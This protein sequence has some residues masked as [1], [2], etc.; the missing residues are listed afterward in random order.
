MIDVL[1]VLQNAWRN[2]APESGKAEWKPRYWRRALWRSQTSKRL[3]EMIPEGITYEVCNASPLVG[4]TSKAVFQADRAHLDRVV[5]RFCPSLTVLLGT[6]AH[7]A[8]PWL[9]PS[10]RVLTG[11]HPAYR[12]LFKATTAE[13]REKI[14]QCLERAGR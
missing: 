8:Q 4:S 10:T 1:F 3:R 13:I 9:E 14:M 7:K 2:G 11:P 6:V 5:A 12:T